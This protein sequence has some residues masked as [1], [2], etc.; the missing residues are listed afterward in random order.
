MHHII[1]IAAL[2]AAL[3]VGGS[4]WAMDGQVDQGVACTVSGEKDLP[5]GSGGAA[6]LCSEIRRA[7]GSAHAGVQ[8]AVRVKRFGLEADVKLGNGRKLP[9]IGYALSDARLKR[10]NFTAFA[11]SIADAVAKQN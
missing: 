6:A 1:K 3:A 2:W 4:A 10:E 11:R 7:V 9:T 5:R 8:V